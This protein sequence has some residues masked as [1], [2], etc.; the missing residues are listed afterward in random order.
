M[1]TATELCNAGAGGA[2]GVQTL[3]A[4]VVLNGHRR[5]LIQYPSIMARNRAEATE[6]VGYTLKCKGLTA[7]EL[8]AIYNSVRAEIPG[9]NTAFRNPFLP[10]FGARV[11]HEIL[12]SL[13]PVGSYVGK[14]LIE[15]A[16]TFLP[17]SSDAR[18][19]TATASMGRW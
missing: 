4:A 7:E 1:W 8:L 3:S 11:L 6:A 16:R 5:A 19:P 14:K 9:S 10:E 18:S 12:V 17:I 15:R 13:P 2:R